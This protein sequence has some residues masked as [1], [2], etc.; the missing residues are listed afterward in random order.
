MSWS[1]AS[2]QRNKETWWILSPNLVIRLTISYTLFRPSWINFCITVLYSWLLDHS[3]ISRARIT[4]RGCESSLVWA[5]LQCVKRWRE[6]SHNKFNS[7][8]LIDCQSWSMS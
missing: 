2:L 8:T 7:I 3:S 6:M 4:G 5:F 1:F